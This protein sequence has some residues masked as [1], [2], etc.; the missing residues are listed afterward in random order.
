MKG[1][2]KKLLAVLCIAV[3][4]VTFTP[5]TASASGGS[6]T[7]N[8]SKETFNVFFG[9]RKTLDLE[10]A[11]AAVQFTDADREANAAEAAQEYDDIISETLALFEPVYNDMAE[12]IQTTYNID[13]TDDSGDIAEDWPT[14]VTDTTDKTADEIIDEAWNSISD[15]DDV[16][17]LNATAE[18]YFQED[19]SGVTGDASGIPGSRMEKYLRY[20]YFK[21]LYP[22]ESG[23]PEIGT[24]DWYQRYSKVES[25]KGNS[26]NAERNNFIN[27]RTVQ[28]NSDTINERLQSVLSN[29][30]FDFYLEKF[31]SSEEDDNG[32]GKT[33]TIDDEET[34]PVYSG[35]FSDSSADSVH[36]TYVDFSNEDQFYDSELWDSLPEYKNESLI[37]TLTEAIENG[38]DFSVNGVSLL[39]H[40]FLFDGGSFEFT[41]ENTTLAE[42]GGVTNE[43]SAIWPYSFR[44][45]ST[46]DNEWKS[47]NLADQDIFG[48][49]TES[50]TDSEG[51][52]SFVNYF[53][54]LL[55]TLSDFPAVESY[56]ITTG[57]DTYI[58][59]I[60]ENGNIV[61][62]SKPLF[63]ELRD[64]EDS[65][66]DS[67]QFDRDKLVAALDLDQDNDGTNDPGVYRYK[68]VEKN[69]YDARV[70]G[71]K[72]VAPDDYQ[73]FDV[74][75]YGDEDVFFLLSDSID[76]V[77]ETYSA[78][79]LEDGY[80]FGT[81]GYG[82]DIGNYAAEG[83]VTLK[84]RKT[85]DGG[86]PESGQTFEFEITD[87]DGNVVSTATNKRGSVTFDPISLTGDDVGKTREYK[88]VEVGDSGTGGSYTYDDS[89][90]T[91]EV[92]VG[93][94][95]DENGNISD[96]TVV[97]KDSDGNVIDGV[98]VFRNE[99]TTETTSA[100]G[101]IS[102]HKTLDTYDA[103]KS[104]FDQQDLSLYGFTLYA[105]NDIVSPADGTTVL[106]KA[107][108]AVSE[109]VSCDENG[110]A[111]IS[112]ILPGEY[113]LKETKMP[114]GTAAVT[115]EPEIKV[116]ADD[117]GSVSVYVNG[118]KQSSTDVL[119]FENYVSKTEIQKKDESGEY[120]EG[121][122]LQLIDSVTGEVQDTWVTG[123]TAHK[124]AGLE[125]G[126]SY[127]LRE[128][129]APDG[130]QTADDITF[131]PEGEAVQTITM[132][133]RK[134][135]VT[136]DE[137]TDDTDDT[138]DND[139]TDNTG[140]NTTSTDTTTDTSTDTSSGN[141]TTIVNTT[142]NGGTVSS[143]GSSN[144]TSDSSTTV[145]SVDTGDDSMLPE[146]AAVTA[147]AIAVLGIVLAA[148]K[149]KTDKR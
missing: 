148:R 132:T 56:Q 101:S 146:T 109:E 141:G 75:V 63:N 97:Y 21:Y 45:L 19:D 145:K 84:A 67:G 114:A 92:T 41:D 64:P 96:V 136:T 86:I 46:S 125:F 93:D 94:S 89:Y 30:R 70:N 143:T 103:D 59:N 69:D 110:N 142:S 11:G 57:Y 91:A 26:S 52:F 38:Y 43:S 115:S 51:I 3:M 139:N 12:Y 134:T 122:T 25:L 39:D 88:I 42:A 126:R 65:E 1:I 28:L 100:T 144:G 34:L 44:Y 129:A 73:I 49:D 68:M 7:L 80:L 104:I 77:D 61:S 82:L 33:I 105:K 72:V 79:S 55:N 133:D 102:I 111:G 32:I 48:G 81:I 53:S 23:D 135:Q 113:V 119:N 37:E 95:V 131:V 4:C 20:R 128:V 31:D 15:N 140:D 14:K 29:A 16:A 40:F 10:S 108:T 74:V 123:T 8:V 60:D 87:E 6:V 47:Y 54:D 107:G 78:E 90:Y 35:G 24:A 116:A 17:T 85:I 137:D 13:L 66:K 83:S 22:D 71:L 9:V 147:A 58:P 149:R 120:L 99:T 127:T 18:N 76:D 2:R 124:I 117:S 62:V 130:Y 36:L 50:D 118:Q 138:G 5:V 106:Y 98:P 27:K 121:A 112:G